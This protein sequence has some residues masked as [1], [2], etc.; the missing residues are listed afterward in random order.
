MVFSRIFIL[1]SLLLSGAICLM[2]CNIETTPTEESEQGS[3]VGDSDNNSDGPDAGCENI[4]NCYGDEPFSEI[5]VSEPYGI[6]THWYEYD[7]STHAVTPRPFIYRVALDGRS[8]VFRVESY[9]DERGTSG[10][11]TLSGRGVDAP[12]GSAKTLKLAANIKDGAVCVSL[13]EWAQTDCAEGVHDL[14]LRIEFRV[15]A[16]AGF[17]VSNPAIYTASHFTD[18]ESAEIFRGQFDS[19]DAAAAA[20][21]E[22]SR[23]ERLADAKDRPEDSL[24][25]STWHRLS[26]DDAPMAFL[27]ATSSMRLVGWTL[28]KGEAAGVESMSATISASCVD[29]EIAPDSQALPLTANAKGASF[30]FEPD[31]LTLIALCGG[32]G[33]R[34]VEVSDEPYRGLWPASD[35]Y[36][37]VVD[38]TGDAAQI[39][40]APGHFIWSSG[41]E[42]IDENITIPAGLWE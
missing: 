39:R 42:A 3:E 14:V 41:A 8:T 38:T 7:S 4:D 9:Y 27:Q 6:A 30:S 36:D 12:A 37:L 15:V 23:W 22:D 19:L 16:T 33:P 29:L 18:A 13:S 28:K 10:H 21:V 5:F 26:P 11:F 25:F 1:L 31:A 17:A 34:I 40:V 35:T 24:L 32:E 2:G 20:P